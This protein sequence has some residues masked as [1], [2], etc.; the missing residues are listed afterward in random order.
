MIL[1]TVQYM[2]PEQLEG[3][4]ADERTDIFAFGAVLYEMLT[5]RRAFEGATDASLIGNILHT[6]PTPPSS[7]E[8]KIPLALDR[9]VRTCLAK[10]H[11]ARPQSVT[12]LLRD[13]TA[14]R[15]TQLVSGVRGKRV[16]RWWIALTP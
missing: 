7:I 3:N 1:G 10:H 11:G 13:L 16:L 9:L 6:E 12:T 8:A 14:I 5:G 4:P 2:A 15:T